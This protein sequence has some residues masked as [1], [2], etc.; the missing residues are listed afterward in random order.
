MNKISKKLNGGLSQMLTAIFLLIISI[1][2]FSSYRNN[3]ANPT[4]ELMI[5]GNKQILQMDKSVNSK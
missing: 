2:L 4:Q 1:F 5:D 3:I